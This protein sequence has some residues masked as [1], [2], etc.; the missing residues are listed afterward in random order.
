[1]VVG[2]ELNISRASLRLGLSQPALTKQIKEL[3]ERV[4]ERLFDRDTQRVELTEAGRAF[5]AEAERSLFF[6]DKA[7]EAARS[8][9]RG[10]E[11]ILNV[12]QSQY[13]D[14][15]LS[16]ALDAVYLP[17]YPNLRVRTVSGYSPDLSRRV[18]T[19]ELDLAITEAGGEPKQV[20]STLLS[21]AP[22]PAQASRGLA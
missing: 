19:G 13:M 10:A 8:V 9:A 22:F 16:A 20:T 7:I 6:R 1:V 4:G 18:A 3:E 5:V 12:G 11:A 2:E 14:P 15:M 17:S 21:T